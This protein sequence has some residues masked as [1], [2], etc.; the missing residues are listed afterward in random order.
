[1]ASPGR[2]QLI[3]FYRPE[4]PGGRGYWAGS[5]GSIGSIYSVP[6]PIDLVRGPVRF[7]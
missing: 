1:V 4:P 5:K 6:I 3:G 2:Y 7:R